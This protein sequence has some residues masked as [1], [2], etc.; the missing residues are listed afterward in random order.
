MANSVLMDNDVILK[1]CCYGLVDEVTALFGAEGRTI[2]ALGVARYVLGRAITKRKNITDRE[3]AAARLVSLLGRA[4]HIEPSAE[5]VALAAEFEAAAQSFEVELDGGE[6]QLLAV[7]IM[8]SAALLLTGDK[9]AIRAIEPVV[10]EAEHQ[11][12]VAG[13][14]VCLEQLAAALIGRHGAEAIRG[15]VCGEAA[16]DKSLAI[17][18]SCS[19]S[20]CEAPS[21]LEGLASY[22][23]DLR[24]GLQYALA[25][26]DD[27]ASVIP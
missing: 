13:R 10:R 17:C 26:G 12:R 16:V 5:E 15:R 7:L 1:M 11:K 24:R 20:G 8:R 23:R 3:G 6:S 27:L 22:V 9:R 21:I 4:Q 14:I 25:E 19:S 2:H 18:F